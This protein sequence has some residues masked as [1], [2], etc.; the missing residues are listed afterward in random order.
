M[1]R[2]ITKFADPCFRTLK[3]SYNYI[4]FYC[5]VNHSCLHFYQ[6]I[7][8]SNIVFF[9]HKNVPQYVLID[10]FVVQIRMIKIINSV[11]FVFGFYQMFELVYYIQIACDIMSYNQTTAVHH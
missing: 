11:L 3:T 8:T 4:E 6:N 1:S 9:G 2:I 10:Y 7:I 5:L